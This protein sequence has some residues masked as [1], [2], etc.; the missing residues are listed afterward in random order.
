MAWN[1]L[2]IKWSRIW[3]R[4]IIGESSIEG[5]RLGFG[6][7]NADTSTLISV[8]CAGIALDKPFLEHTW[9]ESRRILDINVRRHTSKLTKFYPLTS[10]PGSWVIFLGPISR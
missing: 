7:Q 1:L 4:S 10:Y 9:D 5:S 3:E 8:T 2:S 6:T